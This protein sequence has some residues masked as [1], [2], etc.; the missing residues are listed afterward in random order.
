VFFQESVF[1]LPFSLISKDLNQNSSRTNVDSAVVKMMKQIS[2][3]NMD[4]FIEKYREI[5]CRMKGFAETTNGPVAVQT[6]FEHTQFKS[7]SKN[8]YHTE[9]VIIGP[10]NDQKELQ[11]E[12][13]KLCNQN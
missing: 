2:V 4:L 3:N 8:P 1:L 5:T 6:S 12:F 13:E 11:Q 7:I 9:L 10:H